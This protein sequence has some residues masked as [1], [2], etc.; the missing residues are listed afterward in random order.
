MSQRIFEGY[1]DPAFNASTSMS[2]PGLVEI[3]GL[4]PGHY[5]LEMSGSTGA[6]GKHRSWYH[7]ID[8]TGDAELNV[9]ETSAFAT[10][11]GTVFF[12]NTASVPRASFLLISNPATGEVFRSPISDK[13]QFD[14]TAE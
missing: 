9:N 11:S 12:E 1:L 3:G 2:Q 6:D 14:F 8:L 7:E 10:V 4:P 13:S 5:V